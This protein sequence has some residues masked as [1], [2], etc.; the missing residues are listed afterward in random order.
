MGKSSKKQKTENLEIISSENLNG[1]LRLLGWELFRD[2]ELPE[3]SSGDD[4]RELAVRI[5]RRFREG[6]NVYACAV[7]NG[8][9]IGDTSYKKEGTYRDMS[10][11]C[12][13]VEKE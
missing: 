13:F 4:V 5:G 8:M 10:R 6:E 9:Q 1:S 3:G 7:R 12:Y 11:I 2:D